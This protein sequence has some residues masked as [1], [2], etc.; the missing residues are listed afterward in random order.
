MNHFIRALRTSA[1]PLIAEIKPWSPEYGDLLQG[2]TALSIA[3]DYLTAGVPCLS[4]TTGRWHRGSLTQLEQVASQTN[5]PIL[6]KD[7][8]TRKGQLGE[9]RDAGA[10]AVLL[11][12]QILRRQELTQLAL[13]A[14]DMGLAPFI[15]ADSR[16]QLDGWLLP[17]GCILAVC[18]R[19][20]RQKETDD[21]RV[22]RSIDL[23]PAARACHPE[24]LV[25]ASA[26]REPQDAGQAIKAGFDA[27]LV[28]TAL[29]HRRTVVENCASFIAALRG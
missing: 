9:S 25:S 1:I 6:R 26:M 29:L 27:V 2:R 19:D 17:P 3:Q 23:Y 16:T 21:G 28:G 10:S 7:F 24:L 18:N 11:S 8:I 20:I 4:I 13:S 12:A 22:G 15:E 5:V 14:L